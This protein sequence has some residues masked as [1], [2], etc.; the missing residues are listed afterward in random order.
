M[1]VESWINPL[2]RQRFVEVIG[3]AL[4]E[5]QEPCLISQL[6]KNEK[7][8]KLMQDCSS[9]FH[10]FYL[11]PTPLLSHLNPSFSFLQYRTPGP[12]YANTHP[13]QMTQVLVFG[14]VSLI[15]YGEGSYGCLDIVI[16]VVPHFCF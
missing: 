9:I 14:P 13:L 10:I 3:P 2:L 8:P 6:C 5:R 16:V 1:L 12:F 15:K 11:Q 7:Y 4:G